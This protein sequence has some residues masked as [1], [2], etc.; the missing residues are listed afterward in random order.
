MKSEH[1]H[2][3]YRKKK[4]HKSSAADGDDFSRHYVAIDNDRCMTPKS[5]YS[6]RKVVPELHFNRIKLW[7]NMVFKQICEATTHE[8]PVFQVV[9]EAAAVIR[10]DA[11]NSKRTVSSRLLKALENDALSH[12]LLSSQPE[13]FREI[14][15]RI[16]KLSEYIR[17]RCP[18]E[19]PTRNNGL[20]WQPIL[21][22]SMR[23]KDL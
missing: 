19:A 1:N 2:F 21:N 6:N 5:V 15:E 11:T 13:A 12:E 7:E 3:S 20:K 23:D 8:L 17:N 22:H 4:K 9:Q 14:D 16:Y 10:K 18:K